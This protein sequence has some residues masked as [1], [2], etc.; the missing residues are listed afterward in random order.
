M[1][2][3]HQGLL[4]LCSVVATALVAAEETVWLSDLPAALVQAGREEK[5]VLVDFTGSDWCSACISL[6]RNIL[7]AKPFMQWAGKRFVLVEVDI[8]QKPILP[9][10]LLEKNKAVAEAYGV[11]AFPT[12]MVLNARGQVTG[13]FLGYVGQVEAAVAPLEDALRVSA[14]FDQ[15]VALTG[16]RKAQVLMEAYR[17]FPGGKAFAKHREKLEEDILKHDPDNVTGLKDILQ[18]R[19]QAELFEAERSAVSPRSAAYGQLLERQLA[20]SLEP[21]RAAVLMAKCQYALG[22]ARSVDDLEQAKSLL[23]V[24]IRLQPP[25]EAKETQAYLERF[26]TDLPA[27]LR[28][29]QQNRR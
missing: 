13:G 11:A 18:V 24:V 6:R 22:T 4:C 20:E 27:L 15:A 5:H 12:I 3:Y 8:P 10:G 1:R 7:D 17:L 21:N 26:F 25:D 28:L 2:L 23:E 16:S 19:A 14:L 9:A 29:L